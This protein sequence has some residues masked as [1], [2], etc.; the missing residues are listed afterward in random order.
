VERHQ[1]VEAMTE[2][3]TRLKADGADVNDLRGMFLGLFVSLSRGVLT[4]EQAHAGLDM[5]WG[6]K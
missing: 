1:L 2:M 6:M 3:V 5:V 4:I